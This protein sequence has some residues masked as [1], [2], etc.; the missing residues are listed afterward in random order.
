MRRLVLAL[1][2]AACLAVT[3]APARAEN[4]YGEDTR[5]KG[6][7]WGRGVALFYNNLDKTSKRAVNI[8]LGVVVL[9]VAVLAVRHFVRDTREA[10]TPRQKQPWEVG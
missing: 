7:G 9:V 10:M 4:D 2:A 8:S 1:S 6:R 5:L 3:P